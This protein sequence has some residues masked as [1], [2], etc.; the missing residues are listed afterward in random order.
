VLPAHD[1]LQ[2]QFELILARLAQIAVLYMEVVTILRGL[3]DGALA[4][5][6]NQGLHARLLY[7]DDDENYIP[8]ASA[9]RAGS[10][11]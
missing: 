6:A 1:G 4:N 10:S 5:V 7:G 11:H 3:F 2:G 9:C 8:T